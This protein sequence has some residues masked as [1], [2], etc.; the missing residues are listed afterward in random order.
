VTLLLPFVLV[1]PVMLLA[2]AMHGLAAHGPGG[3]VAALALLVGVAEGTRRLSR[4]ARAWW[5]STKAPVLP[6]RA[7]AGPRR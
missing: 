4:A 2:A 3:W 7:R 6:P 1:G 5:A